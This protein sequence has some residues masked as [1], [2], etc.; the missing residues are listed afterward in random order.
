MIGRVLYVVVC[1]KYTQYHLQCKGFLV[2][3]ASVVGVLNEERENPE[4]SER[5]PLTLLSLRQFTLST[6]A[7]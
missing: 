7:R 4:V 1:H 5:F 2:L 3:V 6:Q